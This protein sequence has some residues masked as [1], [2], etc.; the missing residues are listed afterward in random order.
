MAER[1]L[2]LEKS[3]N[4]I[5]LTGEG[6]TPGLMSETQDR[7]PKQTSHSLL[8][9]CQQLTLASHKEIVKRLRC[10]TVSSKGRVSVYFGQRGWNEAVCMGIRER[11]L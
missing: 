5:V 2:T 4:F 6:Q 10:E 1:T 11:S 3:P 9:T 8:G 7:P